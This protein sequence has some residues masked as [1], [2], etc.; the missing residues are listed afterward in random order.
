MKAKHSCHLPLPIVVTRVLGR[1]HRHGDGWHGRAA[2]AQTFRPHSWGR[3]P[4]LFYLVMVPQGAGEDEEQQQPGDGGASARE[5]KTS[6]RDMG[7][8]AAA[9]AQ[10]R[11]RSRSRCWP[12]R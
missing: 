6:S 8:S 4:P 1:G 7:P 12:G 5:Q 3:H 9:T 10:G 2:P 11:G